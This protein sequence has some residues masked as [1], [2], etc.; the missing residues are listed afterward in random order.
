MQNNEL[1][2]RKGAEKKTPKFKAERRVRLLGWL[3]L[4]ASGI[5]L[6]IILMSAIQGQSNIYLFLFGAP[7]FGLNFFAGYLSIKKKIL[8]YWLSIVNQSIQILSFA[9]GSYVYNYSGIG[10]IYA[11]FSITGGKVQIGLSA[12][13]EP[14]F[15]ILWGIN[16][17]NEYFA[18]DILAIFFI[19]VL[20][21][22]V[23]FVKREKSGIQNA[24]V[25]GELEYRQKVPKPRK[26]C[27]TCGN[28]NVRWASIEDGGIGYW[29]P[30]CKM[31]LMEMQ[32]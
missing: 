13:I 27:P 9:V 31:S 10:G 2:R 17:Q 15:S 11:Y 24:Q 8:G 3:Q 6:F 25:K 28:S 18:V 19:G 7:A 26:S 20:L 23:G 16:V 5:I 1:E 30:D 14:G 22:A 29:C 32:G 4:T 21:S 12:S